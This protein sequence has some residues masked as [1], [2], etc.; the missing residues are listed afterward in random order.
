MGVQTIEEKV[1]IEKKQ[2]IH[3]E[4]V[5]MVKHDAI[6]LKLFLYFKIN[7]INNMLGV[8]N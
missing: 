7:A 8:Y 4:W 5:K 3:S 2:L 1:D 6:M